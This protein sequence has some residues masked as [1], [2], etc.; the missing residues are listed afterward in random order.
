[1][2]TRPVTVRLADG[3]G[4]TGAILAALCCAGTPFI[5]GGLT[6]VGLGFLRRDL[7]LWPLML[8]SLGVAL[9]GFW[10]GQRAHRRHGPM[11]LG[12]AGA[13]S[14]S[15]GV[16]VV[17]GFPAMELIYGGSV[18]L[19]AATLWNVRARY[20]CTKTAPAPT[21]DIRAQ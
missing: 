19:I 7:I 5:V 16:M 11:W 20:E 12:V 9:W 17:H 6:A 1:M 4:V 3:A 2:N 8:A 13:V 14:L 18:A 15:A 10:K 21:S